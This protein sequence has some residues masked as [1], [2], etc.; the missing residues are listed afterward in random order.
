M[1][2][3]KRNLQEPKKLS[4]HVNTSNFPALYIT[5]QLSNRTIQ[6]FSDYFWILLTII[7]LTYLPLICRSLHKDMKQRLIG[8][9]QMAISGQFTKGSLVNSWMVGK[10]NYPTTDYYILSY[11]IYILW[12]TTT[13]VPV[14]DNVSLYTLYIYILDIYPVYT[15]YIY[16]LSYIYTPCLTCPPHQPTRGG[17]QISLYVYPWTCRPITT[18]GEGRWD[19]GDRIIIYIQL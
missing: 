5:V 14:H 3:W 19:W 12:F 18:K 7:S 10:G 8:K 4:V 16:T 9:P 6:W 11:T 17:D 13:S 2:W 15:I 1:D